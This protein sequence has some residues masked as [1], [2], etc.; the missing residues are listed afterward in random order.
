[1]Q[2]QPRGN[3]VGIQDRVLG[4]GLKP[5]APIIAMYIQEIGRMLALPHGAA[6]TAPPLGGVATGHRM[7]RQ[8]IHQ[9]LRYTDRPHTWPAAAMRNAERFMQVNVAHI[10]AQFARLRDTDHRVE[11]RAIQI[12]LAAGRMYHFTNLANA[13]SNTPCVE[14]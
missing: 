8:E 5:S 4:G 7:T 13:S 1:M 12:H 11:V 10:R 6:L 14:G 2:I 9:M 3:V